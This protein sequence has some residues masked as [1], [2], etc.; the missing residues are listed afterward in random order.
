MSNMVTPAT[1][2]AAESELLECNHELA[3]AEMHR[4]RAT[5]ERLVD[6]EFLGTGPGGE[7]VAKE[8][9]LETYLS[10]AVLLHTLTTTDHVVRISGD[11]GVVTAES[12]MAGL[13][14]SQPFRAR[15]SYTDVWIRRGGQWRLF[16]SHAHP[17]NT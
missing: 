14:Q 10:G 1:L 15:L 12:S 4:D 9:V 17:L 8:D 5:L 6:D 13:A 7:M 3:R 11:T 16:A 2:S